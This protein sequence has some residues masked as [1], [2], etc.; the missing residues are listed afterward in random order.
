MSLSRSDSA[1][2]SRS[3]GADASPLERPIVRVLDID[4]PA[5]LNAILIRSHPYG[6]YVSDPLAT[7]P[8][9]LTSDPLETKSS[10]QLSTEAKLEPT[11][12][13][14]PMPDT[15]DTRASDVH[16]QDTLVE[17]D[18]EEDIAN[19]PTMGYEPSPQRRKLNTCDGGSRESLPGP[20]PQTVFDFRVTGM[21]LDKHADVRGKCVAIDVKET[22][23]ATTALMNECFEQG[24]ASVQLTQT[25]PTV[26]IVMSMARTALMSVPGKL[27]RGHV[28]YLCYRS[29]I[30]KPIL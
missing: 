2:P 27:Q 11:A 26:P 29:T 18:D 10:L 30:A 8:K 22:K 23:E 15:S 20:P 12:D 1:S 25:V 9:A 21:K 24:A 19:L 5:H 3:I 4:D 16:N 13:S 6:R 17:S 7:A 28:F 14:L